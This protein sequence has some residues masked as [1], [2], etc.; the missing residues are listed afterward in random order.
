MRKHITTLLV[1]L[2]VAV[3]FV[4]GRTLPLFQPADDTT[5]HIDGK[6]CK[7]EDIS[8]VPPLGSSNTLVY[9]RC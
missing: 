2:L 1:V 3:A 5:I 8:H 9:V 6:I 4:L 7:V